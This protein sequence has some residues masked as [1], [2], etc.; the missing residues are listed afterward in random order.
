MIRSEAEQNEGGAPIFLGA[1]VIFGS[2]IEVPLAACNISVGTDQNLG[3][4]CLGI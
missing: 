2:R 1:V 3:E 4:V